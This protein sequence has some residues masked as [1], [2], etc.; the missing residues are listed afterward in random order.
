MSITSMSFV[1][2]FLPLAL[3]MYYIANN[4]VKPYILLGLSLIFYAFGSLQ[5][6]MLFVFE[7]CLTVF[8]G[9]TIYESSNQIERKILFILGILCNVSMLAYYKYADIV[10]TKWNVI[11]GANEPIKGLVFPLGISFFTFKAISYLVDVYKGKAEL[12]DKIVRDALYLSFFTQIQSG[13]L[14]RYNESKPVMDGFNSQL[15]QTGVYRFLVGFSKKVIISSMLSKIYVEVF[16]TPLEEFST[17]YAWLGVICFFLQLLCD[18]EGYSDMAIGISAMFGYKCRENFNYPFMTESING[19][20]GR[21]H[22]SL[23]AW[24]K[25]YVY[26]P[27]GGSRNKHK[28]RVYFN[29][30]VVWLLT[31]IWHGTTG[32]YVFWA[33]GTFVAISIEKMLGFPNRLK[34][35]V[36]KFVYRLFSVLVTVTMAA[37]FSSSNFVN[38]LRYIKRM[39]DFRA[40]E[41]IDMRAKFLIKD[42]CFFILVALFLCF[43]I[44]PFI[45]K[46]LEGKASAAKVFELCKVLVVVAAF[47]WSLSF[48]VA[49][50]NNPFAYANF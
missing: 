27:L 45:E 10:I 29:L 17:L 8:I 9:R 14:T 46:K 6:I 12:T 43:P 21:W 26:I 49:G 50:Q 13:P 11:T 31:G 7:I 34:T 48:V 3:A 35:K 24:F 20:W 5:Y 25:D 40:N 42:N 28:W 30:L 16:S 41:I 19:F 32:N 44:V 38:G 37:M 23:G 4:E 22:I 18:F 47:I 15:F 39:Y 2:A 33:L 1:F 36:G